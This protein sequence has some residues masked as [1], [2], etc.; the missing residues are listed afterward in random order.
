MIA[1]DSVILRSGRPSYQLPPGLPPIHL[2]ADG[3]T[4]EHVIEPEP[5]SKPHELFKFANDEWEGIRKQFDALSDAGFIV[6]SISP[7][8]S[9]FGLCKRK[10]IL[11]V[12]T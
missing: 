7:H 3:K 2:A 11:S 6:L 9:W 8:A 4:A 12:V 1:A 10:L 5:T